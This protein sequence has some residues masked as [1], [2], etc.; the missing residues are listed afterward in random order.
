MVADDY[1]IRVSVDG[2]DVPLSDHCNGNANSG[3][4]RFTVSYNQHWYRPKTQGQ[5]RTTSQLQD[6]NIVQLFGIWNFNEYS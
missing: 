1:Y 2:K 6:I 4:C 3:D 5:L